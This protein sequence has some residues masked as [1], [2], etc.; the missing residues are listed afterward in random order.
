MRETIP[1]KVYEEALE[2]ARGDSFVGAC[3]SY[4]AGLTTG[5]VVS[6]GVF[7]WL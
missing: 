2:R 4:L 6:S 1:I 5:I 3:L 7:L